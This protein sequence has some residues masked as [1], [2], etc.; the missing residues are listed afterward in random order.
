MAIAPANAPLGPVG[1]IARAFFLLALVHDSLSILAYAFVPGLQGLAFPLLRG[2]RVLPP[3]ADLRFVTSLS[4]CGINLEH[5]AQGKLFG[6]SPYSLPH[7]GSGLPYP[8]LSIEVAR[9]LHVQGAHT[10]I[11]GITM[12]LATMGILLSLLHRLHRPGWARD[13]FSGLVLLSFPLQLALERSNIDLVIFVLLTS[14]AAALASSRRWAIPIAAGI[15]WLTV[16]MK[17]YPIAGIL[18]WLG[19]SILRRPRFDWARMASLLG[20]TLGLAIVLPWFLKYG[21]AA[22]QPGI[23]PISHGFIVALP[24]DRL[25]NK[26]PLLGKIAQIA[27]QPLLGLV[28][29]ALTLIWCARVHLSIHWEELLIQRADGFPRRFLS[30]MP[31][32]LGCVWLGCFFL[33]SSYDYR[34]I[35][36]LPSFISLL[37]LLN[38]S[39]QGQPRPSNLLLS[40]V[41]TAGFT[42]FLLPLVTWVPAKLIL[43]FS[44]LTLLSDLFLMPVIAGAITALILPVSLTKYSRMHSEGKTARSEHRYG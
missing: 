37:A 44:G 8:P 22:P 29:F 34:L 33:S 40:L 36:A 39:G 10:G 42:S 20:A 28:V 25:I 17:L 9:F 2:L 43:P 41:A 38:S 12:G 16:V 35:L 5:L 31:A 4:E 24:L 32:L 13:L 7:N 18:T 26:A 21:D 6:C 3:F 14:L 23:G 15:S 30:I 27:P 19:L 11:L 1:L